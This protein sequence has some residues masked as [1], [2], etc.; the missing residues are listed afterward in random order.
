MKKKVFVYEY[1]SGG[2]LVDEDPQ[3]ADELMPHGLAMRDALVT[4]LLRAAHCADISAVTA[5]SCPRAGV[6]PVGATDVQPAAGESAPDFVARQAA[7]HDLVWL[8]APESG[9]LLAQFARRVDPARWLGCSPDAIALTT[10]KR[11]TLL[12]LAA[13]G[14]ATPLDFEAGAR[15]W[16][17][18]PDD[19]AGAIATHVHAD[20]SAARDEAAQRTRAGEAVTLEPWVDGDA[21]S[22]SLACSVGGVEL[23]SVNRQQIVVD[24]GGQLS[25]E[26]VDVD[27]M[28]TSDPRRAELARLAS[29]VGDAIPGLRGFVGVDLV[30]HAQHGPVVIEVNP[31]V[32]CAYVGLSAALGRNLAAELMAGHA[33]EHADAGR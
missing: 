8:V 21:L 16:I 26:G 13:S 5:A 30:W 15:R 25:F 12:L 10:G 2:G 29:Q 6:L 20:R 3:V 32:T 1:L 23:L 11:A 14:I 22:L 33:E 9:G 18:K 17:T 4:D 31:R 19:G 28:I 24:A 27:V 7:R